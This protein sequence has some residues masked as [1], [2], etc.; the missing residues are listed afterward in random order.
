MKINTLT[1]SVA[2]L[3]FAA[4]SAFGQEAVINNQANLDKY[5]AMAKTYAQR[6]AEE[7]QIAARL[8]KQYEG[9]TKSPNPY[10]SAKNLAAYYRQLAETARAYAAEQDKLARN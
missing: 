4:V 3:A 5:L 9:W 1:M 7:E 2:T 10:R 8:E 6:Q